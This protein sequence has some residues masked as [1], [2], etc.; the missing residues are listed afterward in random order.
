[1]EHCE[2]PNELSHTIDGE[3][4]DTKDIE[5]VEL[6]KVFWIWFI[7]RTLTLFCF[8]LMTTNSL[9]FFPMEM[10]SMFPPLAC[11]LSKTEETLYDFQGKFI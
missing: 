2:N 7:T 8:F 11:E 4:K 3:E 1:M 6:G 9:K 5:N 10:E